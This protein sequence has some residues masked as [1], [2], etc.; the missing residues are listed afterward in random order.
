M[1]PAKENP[2]AGQYPADTDVHVWTIPHPL[3]VCRWSPAAPRGD[4][5]GSGEV[6]LQR[7]YLEIA[8]LVGLDSL[9]SRYSPC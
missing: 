1:W 2:S 8:A 4:T 3:P 6:V 7:A 9:S 5:P